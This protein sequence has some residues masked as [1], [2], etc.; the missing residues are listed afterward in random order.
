MA[1]RDSQSVPT[2]R[3]GS[4]RAG[5]GTP[6]PRSP[7]SSLIKR[8]T[9]WDY[10]MG[11]LP[12]DGTHVKWIDGFIPV[13]SVNLLAVSKDMQTNF[14]HQKQ[15]I[16][17]SGKTCFFFPLE[18]CKYKG[19]NMQ[20]FMGKLCIPLQ[21]VTC[22]Q[23]GGLDQCVNI[24]EGKLDLEIFWN[25]LFP[26]L[27][28]WNS[29]KKG[30]K[31]VNKN[32]SWLYFFHIDIQ[33]WWISHRR[34]ITADLECQIQPTD[35]HKVGSQKAEQERWTQQKVYVS[36]K[37]RPCIKLQENWTGFLLYFLLWT[38]LCFHSTKGCFH[39]SSVVLE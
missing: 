9:L 11:F 22:S 37:Y 15:K 33:L 30:E 2:H 28:L 38:W 36:I 16:S 8:P 17:L 31:T 5:S 20:Q 12:S 24:W 13:P 7:R 29:Y 34:W 39:F 21:C 4:Q 19:Q 26:L 32:M 3:G 27:R 1:I 6:H 14:I 10:V 25:I 35:V 18:K 23:R